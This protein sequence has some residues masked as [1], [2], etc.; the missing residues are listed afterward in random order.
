MVMITKLTNQWLSNSR[1]NLLH[2]FE[3]QLDRYFE[4]IFNFIRCC[5]YREDL[6]GA[7]ACTREHGS[8]L[9]ICSP[10]SSGIEK[11]NSGTVASGWRCSC[12]TRGSRIDCNEMGSVRHHKRST[13]HEFW[14]RKMLC[15]RTRLFAWMS[16]LKM[17]MRT[18]QPPAPESR[19]EAPFSDPPMAN[20]LDHA[21]LPNFGVDRPAIYQEE[22]RPVNRHRCPP[23]YP[24]L[25]ALA[26]KIPR[27]RRKCEETK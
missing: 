10:S 12:V 2:Q 7:I 22:C 16:I 27:N 1:R 26:H 15:H 8:A 21:V 11:G 17:K 6:C 20:R 14:R 25:P 18:G 3:Q 9:K 24:K 4:T 5:G 13:L 19:H 23:L